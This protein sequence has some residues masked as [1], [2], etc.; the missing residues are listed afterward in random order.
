MDIH[1][2]DGR[3]HDT[4][5]Q[6]T[7]DAYTYTLNKQITHILHNHSLVE[8]RLVLGCVVVRVNEWV[9]VRVH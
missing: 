2:G 3:K 9:H 6:M 1:I 7:V 8:V 4:H 5:V